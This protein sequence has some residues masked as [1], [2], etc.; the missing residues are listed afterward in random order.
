MLVAGDDD[1]EDTK[2]LLRELTT[3]DYELRWV[4]SAEEAARASTSSSSPYTPRSPSSRTARSSSTAS[5]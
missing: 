3:A 2:Q 5:S 1:R 4:A